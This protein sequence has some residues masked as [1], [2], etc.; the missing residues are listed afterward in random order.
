MNPALTHTDTHTHAH[1][2]RHHHD[3]T[4][5]LRL[6]CHQR[7]DAVKL[8]VSSI[9]HHFLHSI[10]H[11][12][13]H[14]FTHSNTHTHKHTCVSTFIDKHVVNSLSDIFPHRRV[15][16]LQSL[17]FIVA[18]RT[19]VCVCVCVCARVR[20]CVCVCVSAGQRNV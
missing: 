20:V 8:P 5:T 3:D 2:W 10:I 14:I 18:C 1:T 7:R 17:S 6:V 12:Q 19:C 13:T 16:S 9:K 11:T 4:H 15:A